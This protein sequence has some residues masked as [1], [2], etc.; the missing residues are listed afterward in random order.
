MAIDDV[1]DTRAWIQDQVNHATGVQSNKPG[2]KVPSPF[3]KEDAVSMAD[4]D[5][6]LEIERLRAEMAEH[7]YAMKELVNDNK[8]EYSELKSEVKNSMIEMNASLRVFTSNASKETH[9]MNANISRWMLGLF[10]TLAL[11]FGALLFNNIKQLEQR[12]TQNSPQQP[13]VIVVPG[14]TPAQAQAQQSPPQSKQ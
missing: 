4:Q 7:R 5:T 2:G 1:S 6:K 12:P 9:E 10:V 8:T 3:N 11:G 13:T 14:A